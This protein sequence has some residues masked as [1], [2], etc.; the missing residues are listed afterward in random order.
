MAS[1][2]RKKKGL[3]PNLYEY[4][5]GYRYKHPITKE[6]HPLGRDKPRAI[7]AARELNAILLPN[8]EAMPLS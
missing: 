4:K 8:H 2:P 6:W 7:K 5:G 3:C 1:R